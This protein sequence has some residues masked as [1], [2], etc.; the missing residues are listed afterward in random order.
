MP[1]HSDNTLPP[2]LPLRFPAPAAIEALHL[3]LLCTV[4]SR[5]QDERLGTLLADE[6]AAA[7]AYEIRRDLKNKTQLGDDLLVVTVARCYAAALWGATD[8]E[9][10]H[11]LGTLLGRAYLANESMAK[12]RVLGLG[13][14]VE[15]A[16]DKTVPPG[17]SFPQT[18]PAMCMLLLPVYVLGP[19][20]SV[21][22][23][24]DR[25]YADPGLELRASDRPAPHSSSTSAWVKATWKRPPTSRTLSS[26]N[27]SRR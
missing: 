1:S 15:A 17:S 5:D 18:Y 3:L 8:W 7:I 14:Q 27:C 10:S 12:L 2:P 25:L 4:H 13:S 26:M 20:D 16:L 6:A 21:E 22:S 9:P 11:A 23:F 24:K 19:V